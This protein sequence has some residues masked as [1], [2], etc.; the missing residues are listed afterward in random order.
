MNLMPDAESLIEVRKANSETEVLRSK[1]RLAGILCQLQR[2]LN[3]FQD[4]K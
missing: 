2:P 3:D 1:Q 4:S